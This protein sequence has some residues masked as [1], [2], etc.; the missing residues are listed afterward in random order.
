M[1][2]T[3]WYG[4]APTTDRIALVPGAMRP[5]FRQKHMKQVSESVRPDGISEGELH[6]LE[7]TNHLDNTVFRCRLCKVQLSVRMAEFPKCCRRL[8]VALQWGP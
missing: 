6:R 2:Y 7:E 8:S 5:L 3:Q 1:D 4:L